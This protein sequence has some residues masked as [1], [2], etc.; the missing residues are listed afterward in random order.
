[1]AIEVIT[2]YIVI[3]LQ[4]INVLS[5]LECWDELQKRRQRR[6][7]LLFNIKHSTICTITIRNSSSVPFLY[8]INKGLTKFDLTEIRYGRT[9]PT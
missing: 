7:T 4:N 5:F 8:T 1:M 3:H 9:V 2:F 6:M